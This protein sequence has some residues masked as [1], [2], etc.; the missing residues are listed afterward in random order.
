MMTEKV[1]NAVKKNLEFTPRF[2]QI[3]Y[4]NPLY[5]KAFEDIGFTEV[6]YSK[7]MNYFEVSILNFRY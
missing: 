3:V 1:A 7:T 2:L 6:Y 5:K 4:A